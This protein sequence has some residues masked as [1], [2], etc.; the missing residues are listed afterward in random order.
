MQK[1]RKNKIDLL[2]ILLSVTDISLIQ[3]EKKH[4]ASSSQLSIYWRYDA[5]VMAIPTSEITKVTYILRKLNKD[6]GIVN[7]NCVSVILFHTGK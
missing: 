2:Q 4:I 6:S 5:S 1:H 3:T 7:T